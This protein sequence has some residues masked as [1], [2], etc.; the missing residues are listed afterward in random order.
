MTETT[1][2]L[3][4]QLETEESMFV[5]TAQGVDSDGDTL[6]LR[7]ITPSTLYF[8]S[9]LLAG[10]RRPA[11]G[12][13]GGGSR[14]RPLTSRFPWCFEPVVQ[15]DVGASPGSRACRRERAP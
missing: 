14:R 15:F 2:V 9:V 8:P 7:G 1:E 11:A 12:E 10:R 5:Q 6:T 13:N 3:A 4:E